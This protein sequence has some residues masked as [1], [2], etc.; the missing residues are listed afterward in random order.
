MIT[1]TT[2][3]HKR[4]REEIDRTRSVHDARKMYKN[5]V[6]NN[7]SQSHHENDESSFVLS[8][9]HPIDLIEYYKFDWRA[10][11]IYIN[12]RVAHASARA[13]MPVYSTYVFIYVY[14]RPRLRSV[15]HT[16]FLKLPIL[17]YVKSVK[18]LNVAYNILACE[19]RIFLSFS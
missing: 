9:N 16:I 10:S 17:F 4:L 12:V 11:L 6:D 1:K 8:E 14:L 19:T 3:P 5:R 2:G 15:A 13:L 18:F 7:V